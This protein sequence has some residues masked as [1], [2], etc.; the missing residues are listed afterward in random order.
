ML[1]V[2]QEWARCVNVQP[3]R[4]SYACGGIGH[5]ARDCAI[6]VA[7][8][9]AQASVSTSNA[10]ASAG[11]GSAQVFASAAIAGVL[12]ADAL[13]DTGSAF[14][15]LSIVL[16]SRL[17]DAPAIQPFTRAAPD[18]VGVG[19]ASAEIRGYVDALVEV[20]GITVHHSLLVVEGLAFP[21]L[22]GIDILRAHG[23]ILKLDESTPVRLRIR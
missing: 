22:I 1:Q 9:K 23:A 6:C 17:R 3:A 12:I 13:I 20:S 7:K 19:G 21:L 11:K 18:I 8:A 2:W 15:M 4:K 14:S 5:M 16:Y 10:V